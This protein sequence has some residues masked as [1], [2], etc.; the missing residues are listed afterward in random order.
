MK[1]II[2]SIATLAVI[3][4]ISGF[5]SLIH[6]IR[7]TSPN[8]IDEFNKHLDNKEKEDNKIKEIKT[9]IKNK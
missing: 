3:M 2:F 1:L 5:N 4:V 8:P 6:I 9:K 7:G